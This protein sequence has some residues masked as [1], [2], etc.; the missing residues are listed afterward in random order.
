MS[1]Q[2]TLYRAWRTSTITNQISFSV[3]LDEGKTWSP[4]QILAG[5][6]STGPGLAVFGQ[7]VYCSWKGEPSD[8]RFFVNHTADGGIWTIGVQPAGGLTSDTPALSEGPSVE[9]VPSPFGPEPVTTLYVAWKGEDS[10]GRMFM[11]YTTDGTNWLNPGP[12]IPGLTSA[13]PALA[14]LANGELFLVWKGEAG[15]GRMFCDTFTNG[16]TPNQKGQIPGNTSHAPSITAGP[17]NRIYRLW[18]NENDTS[19]LISSTTDG[20]TWT[21]E[22]TIP[23]STNFAPA[24]AGTPDA[25][26]ALW[27]GTEAGTGTSMHF[28]ASPDGN[29]WTPDTIIEGLTTDGPSLVASFTDEVK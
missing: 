23:G 4:E 9:S 7:I 24:L 17:G 2:T 16:L 21:P 15:D 1:F 19:M 14:M 5:I 26:Y 3:S 11:S 8:N 12:Q 6:T 10:D 25:L 18:K 27:K 22:V 29:T 20:T 13:A 28:S